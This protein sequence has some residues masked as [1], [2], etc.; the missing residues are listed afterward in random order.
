MGAR[1]RDP[2][3]LPTRAG[4]APPAAD[5]GCSGLASIPQ[6]RGLHLRRSARLFTAEVRPVIAG[7]EN[8]FLSLAFIYTL[9]KEP[10]THGGMAASGR[11]ARLAP[12][13]AAGGAAGERRPPQRARCARGQRRPGSRAPRRARAWALRPPCKSSSSLC[14]DRPSQSPPPCSPSSW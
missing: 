6:V 5:A 10:F 11:G 14:P 7:M 1:A 3:P 13:Q 12:G 9:I 8:S 2:P 4:R